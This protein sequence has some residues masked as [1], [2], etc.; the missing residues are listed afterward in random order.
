MTIKFNRNDYVK[1]LNRELKMRRKVWKKVSGMPEDFTDMT[2]QRQ[3]DIL[4]EIRDILDTIG[5]E[6]IELIQAETESMLTL[7]E[8]S[9]TYLLF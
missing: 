8:Y 3:Y 1:E 7:Q 6:R 5:K 2:Q 4:C 9:E